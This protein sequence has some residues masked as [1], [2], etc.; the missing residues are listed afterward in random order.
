VTGA[1][2]GAARP[3]KAHALDLG[4]RACILLWAVSLACVLPAGI[5]IAGGCIGTSGAGHGRVCGVRQRCMRGSRAPAR[6]PA[7]ALR[8]LTHY[9]A[10]ISDYW[11]SAGFRDI[12][13]VRAIV[14]LPR[15]AWG[16]GPCTAKPA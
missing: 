14:N 10:R 9:L 3:K 13:R 16:R 1:G 7:S 4:D 5:S 6:L 12:G 2:A 8:Y 15:I 11:T